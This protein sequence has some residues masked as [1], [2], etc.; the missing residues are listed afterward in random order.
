MKKIKVLSII[1]F[2]IVTILV[3]QEKSYAGLTVTSGNPTDKV[4][5]SAAFAYCYN[6]RVSNSTLGE[7]KLDPHMM[8]NSDFAAALYLSTSMYGTGNLNTANSGAY[9]Y[10]N[11]N[12]SGIAVFRVNSSNDRTAAMLETYSGSS[13]IQYFTNLVE[14]A[15]TK[16]VE[17]LPKDINA[18]SNKGKAFGEITSWGGS[19][20]MYSYPSNSNSPGVSRRSFL[21]YSCSND[22]GGGYGVNNWNYF[23]PV[24]W[25]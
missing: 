13:N 10:I 17:I 24:I 20:Y 12:R 2:M 4:T 22:A 21:Y 18:E 11:G 15:D 1:V 5:A 9:D 16:Y 8:L 3:M 23:R 19:S 14:F 25:N 6:L 7:N